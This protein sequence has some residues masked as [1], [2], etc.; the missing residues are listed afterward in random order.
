MMTW[1]GNNSTNQ[2]WVGPE[3]I[4]PAELWSLT[5]SWTSGFH[6]VTSVVILSNTMNVKDR[7]KYHS[8]NLQTKTS[9]RSESHR[10]AAQ[11]CK[12][13]QTRTRQCFPGYG[14]LDASCALSELKVFDGKINQF[15]SFT[16]TAKPLITN[17]CV[18]RRECVRM[19]HTDAPHCRFPWQLAG[20]SVTSATE[21]W[22]RSK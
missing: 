20:R 15:Q 3:T 13:P 16:S 5:P 12:L 17:M 22:A 2:W 8:I 1:W 9:R 14:C 11:Q 7:A 18:H 6:R 4:N 19:I 21:L 10:K